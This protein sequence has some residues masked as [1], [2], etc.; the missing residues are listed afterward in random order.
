MLRSR[1]GTRVGFTLI[2]LLVVIAI[3]AILIALLLPAV[4]QAR[5]AARRSTCKN[6]LKQIGLAMQNYHD[7]FGTFPLGSSHTASGTSTGWGPSFWVGLLPY[8]DQ[9]NVYNNLNLEATHAG[10]TG[11]CDNAAVSNQNM[12]FL[13][14]PTDPRPD[15]GF[16][17]LSPTCGQNT[18]MPS[19]VGIAGATSQN[20]GFG[21]TPVER[22]NGANGWCSGSGTLVPGEVIRMRDITDGTSNTMII[23][24]H[25]NWVID[26]A[27]RRA[28]TGYHGWMMGKNS[29]NRMPTYSERH[30]NLVT[31]RYRVGEN[32]YSLNGFNQNYGCNAALISGHTGV[33]QAVFGDGSVRALGESADLAI[34]KR[35][36]TRNDGQVVGEY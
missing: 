32:N 5:E 29:A 26:G 1:F 14:C 22:D 35:L 21:F 28:L 10:Y 31:I 36:A 8:L 13:R 19:Y 23:G 20:G 7:T 18:T 6:Q 24:E 4:Q 11:N 16:S 17:D 33:A 12:Q 9:A 2:E 30:F 27:N 34:I 3:I 25:S 15:M